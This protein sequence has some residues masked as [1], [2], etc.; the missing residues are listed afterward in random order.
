MYDG[1]ATMRSMQGNLAA[2][3]LDVV[4]TGDQADSITA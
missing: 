1:L 3:V 4:A 2:A